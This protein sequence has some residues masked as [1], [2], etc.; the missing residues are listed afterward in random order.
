MDVFKVDSGFVFNQV[1]D[2][3]GNVSG[4]NVVAMLDAA[5]ENSFT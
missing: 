2:I 5:Y 4:E 1:Q 3:M